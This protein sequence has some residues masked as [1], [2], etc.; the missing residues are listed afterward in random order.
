M[1]LLL[2]V[3]AVPS[4]TQHRVDEQQEGWSFGDQADNIG[5]NED[6]KNDDSGDHGDENDGDQ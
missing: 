5:R 6:S 4:S 1:L 3:A 2:D